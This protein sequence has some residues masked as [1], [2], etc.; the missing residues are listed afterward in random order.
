MPNDVTITGSLTVKGTTTTVESTVVEVTDPVFTVGQDATDDNLDRGIQFKYNNG[1]SKTGFFGMYDSDHT[2]KYWADATNT[3]EVFS[4]TLGNAAF[5]DIA[6]TLTTAA[7]PNVTDMVALQVVGTISTGVWNGNTV[8]EGYGGTGQ[9]TYA[10][11]DILY[12]DGADSLARLTKGSDDMFLQMN[13]N[14]P[15]WSSTLDGGTF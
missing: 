4:G 1:G 12:A 14:A 11:G 9:N 5:G 6:G 2:F 10:A 3:S 15:A 13:G 8:A 7:Q